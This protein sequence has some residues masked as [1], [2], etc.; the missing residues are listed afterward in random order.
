MTTFT[1][2][3]DQPSPDPAKHVNYTYGMVL[4][5][6]DFT[7][8]F[9]YLAARDRSLAADLAGYGTICGLAVA[10]ELTYD[11]P[12]RGPRVSVSPGA[13]ITP[14]GQLVCVDPAQCAYLVDWLANN[15]AQVVAALGGT[16][17]GTPPPSGSLDIFVVLCYAECLTDQVPVPGEPC[18]TEDELLAPS[19]IRDYFL[20]NLRL[21]PPDDAPPQDEEEAVRAFAGWLRQVPVTA[22]STVAL[23]DFLAA[24][25][26]AAGI[27]QPPAS[28]P[29]PP[30]AQFFAAP[31]PAGLAIPNGQVPEFLRAAFRLWVTELLPCWRAGAGNC[32]CGSATGT[33]GTASPADLGCLTLA[34]LTVDVTYDPPTDR[35]L[36]LAQPSA[37]TIDEEHRPY[38]ID[39][40]VLQEWAITETAPQPASGPGP[41]P[42]GPAPGP[43][44]AGPTPVVAAA[45]QVPLAAMR[46]ESID[47]TADP[48][49]AD[50]SGGVAS[51]VVAAGRFD[52]DGI[53]PGPPFYAYGGLRAVPRR[54]APGE[55][56]LQ[57]PAFEPSGNY[58]VTGS[59]IVE[60]GSAAH[61]LET[62][63]PGP[64][65]AV[66][67][68]R[69]TTL[70]TNMHGFTIQITRFHP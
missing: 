24:L 23:P 18:R 35:Y 15:R 57:F 3:P 64:G 39:L 49:G 6:D 67:V 29:C 2:A 40:R 53:A 34:Q 17:G 52:S 59:V 66:R 30:L 54:N 4:G 45:G 16:P 41:V 62:L 25:R 56:D 43:V 60:P 14:S 47:G 20:L 37:V 9:A 38:L 50:G 12:D 26:T 51:A 31:P 55:F 32:G 10:Y 28:P 69:A 19:R 61:V 33:T 42:P 21:K 11:G 1:A 44:P 58:V 27:G 65:L 5:V 8:E 13:A 7:Q 48:Q 70:G 22:G 63:G 46:P 36:P 68:R